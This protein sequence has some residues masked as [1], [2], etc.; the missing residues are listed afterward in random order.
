M[1]LIDRIKVGINLFNIG[2]DNSEY[3]RGQVELAM[4]LLGDEQNEELLIEL[5]QEANNG[6]R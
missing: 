1:E 4:F 2:S 6:R 5:M 3:L